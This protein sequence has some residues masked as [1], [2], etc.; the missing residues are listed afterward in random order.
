MG[1]AQ[2]L[3]YDRIGDAATDCFVPG[4]AEQGRGRLVLGRDKAVIVHGD[5]RFAGMVN[6]MPGAFLVACVFHAIGLAPETHL[7][8]PSARTRSARPLTPLTRSASM[9]V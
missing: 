8:S 9:S 7:G 6:D 1:L 3:G 2:P 4:P 5:K